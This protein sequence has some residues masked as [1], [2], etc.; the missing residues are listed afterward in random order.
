MVSQRDQ[1]YGY[2]FFLG[3]MDPCFMHGYPRPNKINVD[4]VQHCLT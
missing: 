1:V 3:A 4:L 2:L